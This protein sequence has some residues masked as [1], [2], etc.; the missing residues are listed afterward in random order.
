MMSREEM[1]VKLRECVAFGSANSPY[2]LTDDEEDDLLDFLFE[3]ENTEQHP[4]NN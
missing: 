1:F 2:V 3:L 4:I